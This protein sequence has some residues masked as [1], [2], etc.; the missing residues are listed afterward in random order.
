MR[1]RLKARF[2]RLFNQGHEAQPPAAA[3]TRQDIE[4]KRS[5]HQLG[6]LIRTGPDCAQSTASSLRIDLVIL[7]PRRSRYR[8]ASNARR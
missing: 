6:P 1:V 2:S 5:P 3:R 4:P 7:L 8:T